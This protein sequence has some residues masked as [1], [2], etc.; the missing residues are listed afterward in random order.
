MIAAGV[1]LTL[2]G[3]A[4]PAGEN[5]LAQVAQ[6]AA[7]AGV[8]VGPSGDVYISDSGTGRVVKVANGILAR[9]AGTGAQG[10]GGDNGPALNALLS[11]PAGLAFDGSGNLLIADMQ[12]ARV[13]K[14]SGGVITTVAGGGSAFGDKGQAAAA[15]LG[16]PAAVAVDTAGNLFI[17]DMN[18]VRVVDGASGIITTAVGTGSGGYQGDSGPPTA[19]YLAE[20]N[21]LAVDASGNLLLADTGNNRIR[22]VAGGI[23]TTVAGNGNYGF[24][25]ANG[26]ATSATLAQPAGVAADAA[27]NFYISDAYRVLKVSKGKISTIAGAAAPQG[28]AVDAAGNVYV[29]EPSTHRVRVLSPAGTTC[30]V[31]AAPATLQ[32]AQAGGVVQAGIQTG[33]ACPWTVEAL[34]AW[35]SVAGDPFGAGPGSVNLAVAANSGPPRTATILIGGQNVAVEQ[36]GRMTIAGQVTSRTGSAMPGVAV[37][38]SGARNA[39]ATTDSG[40]NFVFG[41]LDSAASYTVTPALAGYVFAPPTQTFANATANPTANFSAW[42]PPAI[43]GFGPAFASVTQ[44]APTVF[45]PGEVVTLYGSN[46]CGDPTGA[47]PT[48]PDRIAACIV[49]VDGVNLRLYYGSA[50]QINAVLPQTLAV[51][52]HQLAVQRYTDTAY[53]L[54]AA[55][56]D[57]FAFRVDKVA[58]AFVER[59][60]GSGRVLMAQYLDGAYAGP[61]RPVRPGDY[62]TLYLTGIGRKAQT[63]G[64]GAAPGKASAAM[65]TPQVTVEGLPAQISYAGVQPQYPGLD[66]LTLKLPNYTLKPGKST[67]TVQI[68]A[69]ATG[70]TLRYEISAN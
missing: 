29:A 56:S 16:A 27:G 15:Q 30:G 18:R 42:V 28:I 12:N 13:R 10:F 25:G 65:E 67:A 14:V 32:S 37:T 9:V 4:A 33:S 54:Q 61:S 53:R 50:T 21:G 2:A 52:P 58:M 19:A 57:A 55:R 68:T 49:Q 40:G 63:F 26:T 17:A 64:E 47:N 1:I 41:A 24:T 59:G 8:A 38:L 3:G 6:L 70:Q 43:T 46:L 48:L 31:T 36:A 51:G 7:P 5:G 69:P 62:V 45:A 44:P 60:E 34:P 35:I 20:P 39:T 11:S 23:I 66:Q 22:M